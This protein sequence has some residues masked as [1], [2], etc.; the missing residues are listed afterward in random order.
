[1]SEAGTGAKYTAPNLVQS[2]EILDVQD[3][4]D[5]FRKAVR[6]WTRR[7]APPEKSHLWLNAA[8]GAE[9]AEI[10]KWWMRER[11]KVGLAIPNWPKEYGGAGLGLAHQIIIA[12]E[13]AR[14]SAPDSWTFNV[15]LNHVP[16]T[17]IPYGTDYQKQKYLPTVPQATV[18]CQGFSE[19]GAGSDLAALKTRAV[20]DGDHY[21][22]NG[23]KIWSSQSMFASYAI[24]LART[25][26]EVKKQRGIT[27]FIL[28]MKAPGVEVRPIR[29]STGSSTFAE[30]FLTDVRI[31]VEDRV[32]EENLG[33]TIAQAT[34]S[35]ERGVLVFSG[36]ERESAALQRFYQRSLANKAAWL[37]DDQL[38][39]EYMSLFAEHQGVRRMIRD[40]L[41]EEHGET[42]S[43]TP[44]L[45]KF[46]TASVR[47][48][49]AEFR[50]RITGLSG[51]AVTPDDSCI[52]GAMYEYLDSFG[53]TIAAGSNEIMRNMIAERGLGMP[54]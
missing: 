25:N 10:D 46:L 42:W 52:H 48:R 14:A 40:L 27:Y 20:R 51:Q 54:R 30:L 50:V 16:A 1:M 28:D 39:R 7:T 49:L 38:R 29:K 3:D 15:A 11:A 43:M 33:W 47:Q 44:G 23:Q 34:L 35:A 4:L 21:V 18:W 24:L 12:D 17:L 26:T 5:A 2:T 37:D 9:Q 6:E 41:K 13:F 8:Q 36:W 19:P 32:G 22:I 53:G 31:P 45:V